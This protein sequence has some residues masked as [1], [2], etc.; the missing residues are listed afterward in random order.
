MKKDLASHWR[1]GGASSGASGFLSFQLLLVLL[2]FAQM[3][4]PGNFFCLVHDY[5]P[6]KCTFSSKP[7]KYACALLFTFDTGFK[8]NFGQ[9]LRLIS[10]IVVFV[11]AP[12][13]III[14]AVIAQH[15]IF[16][17]RSHSLT[18]TL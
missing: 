12:R 13:L 14:I 9:L 2:G 18:T 1:C 7:E 17:I 3:L 15:T 8:I 6:F 11:I 10:A 4:V 5:F 16:G